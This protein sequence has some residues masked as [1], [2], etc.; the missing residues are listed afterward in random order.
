[1]CVHTSEYEEGVDTR[2]DCCLLIPGRTHRAALFVCAAVLPCTTT[3]T[4]VTAMDLERPGHLEVSSGTQ[5]EPVIPVEVV[6]VVHVRLMETG[7]LL[8]SRHVG[9]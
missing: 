4:A 5:R 7:R 3:I 2:I 8:F 9:C 6:V 1:M